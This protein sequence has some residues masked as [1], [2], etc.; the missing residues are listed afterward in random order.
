MKPSEGSSKPIFQKVRHVLTAGE[1]LIGLAL[2][3]G[4]TV[5]EIR[6]INK[7]GA[8]AAVHVGQVLVPHFGAS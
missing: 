4:V 7:L 5:A 3:Y 8:G 6:S 1:T 2:K